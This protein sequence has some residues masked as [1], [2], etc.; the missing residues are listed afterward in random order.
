MSDIPVDFIEILK[1]G[2]FYCPASAHHDFAH[3]NIRCDRCQKT[4]LKTSIG[5]NKMDI[6]MTC[7]VELEKLLPCT[8]PSKKL[9]MYDKP[10][11]KEES[12]ESEDEEFTLMES[13]M[14]KS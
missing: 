12:S 10:Q 6:C 5:Y 4:K 8:V 7:V 1:N 2:K 3:P 14:F 11:V 13:P 9:K